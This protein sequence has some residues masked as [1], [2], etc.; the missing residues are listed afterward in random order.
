[1]FDTGTKLLYE[2][3]MITERDYCTARKTGMS[4]EDFCIAVPVGRDKAAPPGALPLDH[5]GGN[6][7]GSIVKKPHF[8]PK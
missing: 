4:A 7:I 3:D 1:M 5:A 2:K 8:T 6:E